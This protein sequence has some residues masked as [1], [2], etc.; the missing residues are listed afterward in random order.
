MQVLDNTSREGALY[1]LL[2]FNQGCFHLLKGADLHFSQECVTLTK[3]VFEM[4][5]TAQALELTIHHDG[6]PGTQS[7]TL[8]HAVMR[9]S[10]L[11][12]INTMYI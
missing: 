4:L 9:E 5:G 10:T 3:F 2:Q 11:I 1:E 6:H 12:K 7:L 8:L